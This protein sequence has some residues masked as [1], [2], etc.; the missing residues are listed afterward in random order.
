MSHS[1]PTTARVEPP[2]RDR[3]VTWAPSSLRRRAPR[4]ACYSTLPSVTLDELASAFERDADRH[5]R[6]LEYEYAHAAR[7]RATLAR[8]WARYQRSEGR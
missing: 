8:H 1:E 2:R 5:D 3:R 4:G 6:R 7:R